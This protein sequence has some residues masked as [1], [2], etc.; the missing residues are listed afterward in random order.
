VST[1]SAESLRATVLRALTD[2]A[3]DVDATTLNPALPFREQFDFDSM[4]HLNFV[5][6][7]HRALGVDVPEADYPELASLDGCIRYLTRALGATARP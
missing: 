2:V 6:G 4:D 1:P 7:L 3:P 5:T